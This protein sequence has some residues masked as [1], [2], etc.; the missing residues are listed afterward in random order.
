MMMIDGLFA[1]S[2]ILLVNLNLAQSKREG[3]LTGT[4]FSRQFCGR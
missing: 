3:S 2:E 4:V 1:V